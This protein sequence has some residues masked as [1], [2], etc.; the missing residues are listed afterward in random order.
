MEGEGKKTKYFITEW[1]RGKASWIRF[2]VEG[3]FNLLKGVEECRYA[4]T[5]VRRS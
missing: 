2:G 4:F 3:L 1:S 5:P